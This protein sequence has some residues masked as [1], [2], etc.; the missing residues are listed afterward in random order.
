MYEE[1]TTSPK[2]RKKDR[3]LVLR[4]KEGEKAKSS[5]GLIDPRLFTGE[6]KLHAIMDERSRMWYLKYEQGGLP[7]VLKGIR[8]TKF[9]FLLKYVSEY[10]KK[11]NIQIVEVI[12]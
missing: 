12:D 4:P 6:N 2:E 1:T 7:P 10:F 3:I 8:F 11:R 9:D 5:T